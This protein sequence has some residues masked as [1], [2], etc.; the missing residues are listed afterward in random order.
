MSRLT[1]QRICRWVAPARGLRSA[2]PRRPRSKP[3]Q[4]W[5]PVP[6]ER[7]DPDR[8]RRCPRPRSSRSS[9]ST[10]SSVSA[11]RRS[12]RSRRSRSTGAVVVDDEPVGRG[13]VV[14]HAAASVSSANRSTSASGRPAQSSRRRAR[15][16]GA[17]GRARGSGSR[18]VAWPGV[19]VS[20][21]WFSPR[22]SR[23]TAGRSPSAR[24]LRVDPAAHPVGVADVVELPELAVELPEP[25]VVAHPVGAEVDEPG[26]AHAAVVV[27]RRVAGP[28]APTRRPS[29]RA[30]ARR[31]C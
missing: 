27:A 10:M 26:L 25:R 18:I 21:R 12:G 20:P 23:S 16:G 14:L 31:G 4:K 9:A 3:E 8:T 24:Y 13:R 15:R 11:L 7:D 30:A 28:A 5:S 2:G 29:A 22:M 1:C 17:P 6:D 19:V